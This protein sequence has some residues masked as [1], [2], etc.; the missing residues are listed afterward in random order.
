[1]NLQRFIELPAAAGRLIRC[2]NSAACTV[3]AKSMQLL[4]NSQRAWIA[5]RIYDRA[6]SIG[7]ESNDRVFSR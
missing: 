6:G 4:G 7:R 2:D 1:M 3:Y 5:G